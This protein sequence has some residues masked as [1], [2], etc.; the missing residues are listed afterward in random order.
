MAQLPSIT[1]LADVAIDDAALDDV[2]ALEDCPL[3][4]LDDCPW[5]GARPKPEKDPRPKPND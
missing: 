1:V 4:L 2:V 3:F 5:F